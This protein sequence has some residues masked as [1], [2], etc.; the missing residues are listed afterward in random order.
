M[1]LASATPTAESSP[2]IFDDDDDDD[3][4][5]DEECMCE[6]YPVEDEGEPDLLL[7]R[8]L[9]LSLR[10]LSR[11]PPV[12]TLPDPEEPP[13][14]TE[15]RLLFPLPPLRLLR[16][17]E[18]CCCC[19]CNNDSFPPRSSVEETVDAERDERDDLFWAFLLILVLLP[20]D[21]IPSSASSDA[22]SLGSCPRLP[23]LPVESLLASRCLNMIPPVDVDVEEVD[24][25]LLL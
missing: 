2:F 17:L 20:G 8:F 5:E 16:R 15:L 21:L 10:S 14:S 11:P 25:V 1:I 22:P 23:I 7:F 13:D 9:S 6:V 4:D 19:C 18:S 24:I 3:E 12:I